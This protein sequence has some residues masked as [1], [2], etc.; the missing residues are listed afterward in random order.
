MY[1]KIIN[2]SKSIHHN[3]SCYFSCANDLRLY[4]DT[5]C[6]SRTETLLRLYHVKNDTEQTL[7]CQHRLTH[8]L[9]NLT[10]TII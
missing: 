9:A 10:S 7:S 5:V 2:Q 4:I 8:L 3:S 6:Y 1:I